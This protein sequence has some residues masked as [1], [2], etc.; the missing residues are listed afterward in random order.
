MPNQNGGA[1]CAEKKREQAPGRNAWTLSWL[2]EKAD[3]WREEKLQ[4]VLHGAN[5]LS[6]KR[7]NEKLQA[8]ETKVCDI[9]TP[10][11]QPGRVKVKTVTLE[12]ETS[13]SRTIDVSSDGWD[14]VFWTESSI[15]KFLYPY[16][17]SH[18]IWSDEMDTLKAS[19][20][21][22]PNAF[23]IRH[24]APS[25]SSM[26][27][28]VGAFEIGALDLQLAPQ[29]FSPPDFI[30]LVAEY[31]EVQADATPAAAGHGQDIGQ[32]AGALPH[33]P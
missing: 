7:Q 6:I 28:L 5:G 30:A 14:A 13:G 22:Y 32:P 3:G 15:E 1:D 26:M 19:F 17:H 21:A 8:G 33:T 2:A 20:E 9:E 11:C 23:A 29:W 24:K 10:R 27:S 4:L 16:Y 18:R 12:T 31:L 25:T